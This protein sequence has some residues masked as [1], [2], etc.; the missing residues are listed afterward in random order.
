MASEALCFFKKLDDE[1][2][3]PKNKKN[4]QLKSVMFCFAVLFVDL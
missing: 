1:Q 2:V 3:S 4:N